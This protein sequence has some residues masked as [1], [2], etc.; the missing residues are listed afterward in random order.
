[1]LLTV[2]QMLT[3]QARLQP[4]RTAARDLERSMTFAQWNDRACR[5]ANGSTVQKEGSVAVE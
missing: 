5:L 1:M 4:G 2:G 3:T